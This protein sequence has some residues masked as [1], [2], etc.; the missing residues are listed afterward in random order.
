[1][2]AYLSA[3]PQLKPLVLVVKTWAS[4]RKINDRSKGPV[5]F[6][7]LAQW[8]YDLGLRKK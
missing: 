8:F 6:D 1:V 4:A 7:D 5:L 3:E 2:A